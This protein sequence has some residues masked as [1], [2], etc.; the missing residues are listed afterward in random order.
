MMRHSPF[1]QVAVYKEL[2]LHGLKVKPLVRAYE[3]FEYL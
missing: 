3:G 2:G 1:P